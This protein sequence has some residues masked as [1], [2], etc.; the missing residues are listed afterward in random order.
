MNY[1]AQKG[2]GAQGDPE[3]PPGFVQQFLLKNGVKYPK[4]PNPSN[5]V[6]DFPLGHHGCYYCADNHTFC[7]YPKIDEPRALQRM[8]FNMHC[9]QPNLYYNLIE[10]KLTSIHQNARIVSLSSKILSSRQIQR[11]LNS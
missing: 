2:N 1:L 3:L 8:R 11:T 6:S 10:E 9:H 7:D 4:H 5:L